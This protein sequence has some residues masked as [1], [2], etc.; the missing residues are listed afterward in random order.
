MEAQLAGRKSIPCYI[1]LASERTRLGSH[2]ATCLR[3]FLSGRVSRDLS[4]PFWFARSVTYR[5]CVGLGGGSIEVDVGSNRQGYKLGQV[6]ETS[7]NIQV[8]SSHS[9]ELAGNVTRQFFRGIML[10]SAETLRF[11]GCSEEVE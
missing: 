3:D 8:P 10:T 9:S 11:T 2:Y 1:P 7:W 5:I 4:G 6:C